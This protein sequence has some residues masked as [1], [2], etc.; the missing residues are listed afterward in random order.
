M[1]LIFITFEIIH[2]FKE[3]I[4]TEVRLKTKRIGTYA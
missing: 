2:Y 4:Q 1:D 3:K